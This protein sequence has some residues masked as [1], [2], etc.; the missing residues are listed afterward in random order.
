MHWSKVPVL[1]GA[2]GE[3]SGCSAT[4]DGQPVR[5]SVTSKSTIQ[6]RK[7]HQRVTIPAHIPA[8]GSPYTSPGAGWLH[9][10]R[11]SNALCCAAAFDV[12]LEL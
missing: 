3:R 8:N 9:R 6:P 2:H 12:A 10:I 4:H 11:Q 5:S 1:P 7:D